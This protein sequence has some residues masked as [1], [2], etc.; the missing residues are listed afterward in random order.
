MRYVTE[1]KTEDGVAV[2]EL[3]GNLIGTLKSSVGPHGGSTG[4]FQYCKTTQPFNE[5]G[6]VSLTR[7]RRRIEDR[8]RK[9]NEAVI[10]I[11][12]TL[13]ISQSPAI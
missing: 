5:L 2:H 8:L 9:D 10:K 3:N 11:A 1:T 13:G 6:L 12:E 4:E 7:V